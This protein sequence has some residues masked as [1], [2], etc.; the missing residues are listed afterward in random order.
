MTVKTGNTELGLDRRHSNCPTSNFCSATT[1]AIA[2]EGCS[3]AATFEA[4]VSVSAET[5][6]AFGA[7]LARVEF[8]T[9]PI[10]LSKA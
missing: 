5:D 9:A 8:F 4:P 6:V 3:V 7:M 2:L 10:L 1:G